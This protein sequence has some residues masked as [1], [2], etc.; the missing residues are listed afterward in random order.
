MPRSKEVVARAEEDA[1]GAA[2]KTAQS[3]ETCRGDDV[4]IHIIYI[5]Y[6]SYIYNISIVYEASVDEEDDGL[7]ANSHFRFVAAYSRF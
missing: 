2:Q 1:D 6:T 3:K 5:I 7:P 4:Y